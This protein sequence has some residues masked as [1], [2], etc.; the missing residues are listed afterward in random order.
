MYQD[1]FQM[2]TFKGDSESGHKAARN[3]TGDDDEARQTTIVDIAGM[4]RIWCQVPGQEDQS[5]CD[6]ENM[7]SW[8]YIIISLSYAGFVLWVVEG[9]TNESGFPKKSNVDQMRRTV[10]N[11]TASFVGGNDH[12]YSPHT[13]AGRVTI[14]AA[15]FAVLVLTT[16][17][18]ANMT[19]N[20][21]LDASTKAP[22]GSLAEAV[23]NR[24]KVCGVS[25]IR[26][27]LIPTYPGIESVFVISSTGDQAEDFVNMEAGKCDIVVT[28]KKT[29]DNEKLKPINCV[30]FRVHT[31]HS[32]HCNPCTSTISWFSPHGAFPP[33]M[34]PIDVLGSSRAFTYMRCFHHL[35]PPR[36]LSL[37][38]NRTR[39]G[40]PTWFALWRSPSQLR[41]NSNLPLRGL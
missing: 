27:L 39:W 24:A 26:D 40:I 11:M 37:A 33:L 19:T 1:F 28:D 36:F 17:Y 13:T 2:I 12:R 9:W 7:M 20:K 29:W 34:C 30:R 4:F 32:Q 41:K 5:R 21:I 18:T 35:P 38:A 31:L 22:Y 25:V 16:T 10:F 15:S 23:A 14:L 3:E 6:A 8:L